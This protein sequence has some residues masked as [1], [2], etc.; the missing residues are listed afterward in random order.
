[1]TFKKKILFFTNTRADYGKLKKI[2]LDCEK[3][4]DTYIFVTGMH[5]LK[6]YGSTYLQILKDCKKSKIF[7]FRNYKK[8]NTQDIILANTIFGFNKILKK[9][10]PHLIVTHGDRIETLASAISGSVNNFLV[11]HIEGPE[12]SETIDEH[13]RH[14]ISKLSH[15]HFVSNKFAKNRLCQ[16]GEKKNSIYIIGSPDID[17]M[18]EEN[19]PKLREVKKRYKINFDDYII[20][21]LHPVTT[22]LDKL[23]EQIKNYFSAL[24][25]SRLNFILIYPNNDPG[26]YKILNKILKYKNNK[27]FKII[28]SMRFEYFLRILKNSKA[29]IGNSSSAIREA[30]FYG[31]PS[32]NVG[33]RQN[34]RAPSIKSILNADFN[35]NSILKKINFL[36]GKSFKKEYFFGKGDSSKKILNIFED[37]KFWTTPLQKKFVNLD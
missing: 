6:E 4:F 5:L 32:I 10:N 20:S 19:L 35:S 30:P 3:I 13:L 28:K 23:S 27:K 29:I 26:S 31:I 34:E 33:T 2:I 1:M 37:K 24:E 7:R 25:R 9:I 16:M 18:K 11:A 21:I 14:A 15:I 8:L 17:I 12:T 22:E 36:Y